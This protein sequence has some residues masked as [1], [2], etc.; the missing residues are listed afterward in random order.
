MIMTQNEQKEFIKN[1]EY[2][3]NKKVTD[4]YVE[5]LKTAYINYDKKEYIHRLFLCILHLYTDEN[6]ELDIDS[7]VKE[8]SSVY[9]SKN[10]D[11]N[12]DR[13]L[14][15]QMMSINKL[16]NDYLDKK[17]NICK[18]FHINSLRT[19]VY[20]GGHYS[21]GP[22]C[23]YFESDGYGYHGSS[24]NEES[25]HL[26]CALNHNNIM[27]EDIYYF[28]VSK[29]NTYEYLLNH[30]IDDIKKDIDKIKEF[31]EESELLRIRINSF[32]DNIN[33]EYCLGL[34]SK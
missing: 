4:D 22:L 28:K 14:D 18:S 6:Y 12:L 23:I 30:N 21:Y 17:Y 5:K 16:L 10:N 9:I 29:P 15:L 32:I 8:V 34:K 11:I 27:N 19:T 2:N 24:A 33:K 31:E 1:I 7:V 3:I 13:L 26:L 20:P 25:Y